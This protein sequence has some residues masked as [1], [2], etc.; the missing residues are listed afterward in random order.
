MPVGLKR[1]WSVFGRVGFRR[2]CQQLFHFRFQL[3]RLLIHAVVAHRFVFARV[4]LLL[5]AVDRHMP[6]L[7]QPRFVA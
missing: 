1:I 2:L 6:Q 3:L 7:Y 4:G 5:G